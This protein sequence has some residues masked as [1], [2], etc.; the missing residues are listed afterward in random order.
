MTKMTTLNLSYSP[1][2]RPAELGQDQWDDARSVFPIYL[3]LAKQLTVDIPFPPDKRHLPEKPEFETFSN[4]QTIPSLASCGGFLV[5]SHE[6]IDFLR[7][8]SR[9]F[10]FTA[11]AVPAAI[12]AALAAI[13]AEH[14]Q[15]QIQP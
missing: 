3:A 7:V 11:A 1:P 15:I 4:I 5:G 13:L 8:Q 12:G 10:L 14:R 6:V 2:A 9:A